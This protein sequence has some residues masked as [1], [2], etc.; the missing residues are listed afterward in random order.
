PVAEQATPPEEHEDVVPEHRW[1]HHDGGREDHVDEVAANEAEIGQERSDSDP[2]EG[3]KDRRHG[4]DFKGEEEGS[5]LHARER[6]RRLYPRRFVVFAYSGGELIQR[7]EFRTFRRENRSARAAEG[8][9]R[10][11]LSWQQEA[12]TTHDRASRRRADEVDKRT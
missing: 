10:D 3:R 1:W 2:D 8:S 6:F 7:P 12:V 9:A 11:R 4:G 5:E